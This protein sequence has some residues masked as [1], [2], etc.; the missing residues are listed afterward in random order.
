[1]CR[2]LFVPSFEMIQR[3]WGVMLGT[4][5]RDIRVAIVRLWFVVVFSLHVVVFPLDVAI[6][7]LD[8]IVFPLDVAIFPLDVAI[9]LIDVP[10]VSHSKL[11][12][13]SERDTKNRIAV[14]SKWIVRGIM[15]VLGLKDDSDGGLHVAH[16]RDK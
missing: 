10:I 16:E 12:I 8:V 11:F 3:L 13:V 15:C 6:F 14:R 7:S 4:R 5:A 1:M 2:T 9:R